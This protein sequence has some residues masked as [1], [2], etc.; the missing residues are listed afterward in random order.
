MSQ[1][2]SAITTLF[3]AAALT[4]FATELG[5]A[6]GGLANFGTMNFTPI[7]LG[8]NTMPHN[9]WL[10]PLGCPGGFGPVTAPMTATAPVN[11]RTSVDLGDGNRLEI[12][13][14]SSEIKIFDA[15]G[16][17]TRIW[18]D[19]HV[20]VNGKHV[21]DF[22][23]ATTFELKNGT[24]ITINTEPWQGNANMYVASQLVITHGNQGMVIDGVSQNK[25]GDLS[26]SHG[27]GQALDLMTPDGF[28]VHEQKAGAG[29]S[30]GWTS[31]FTGK[32]VTQADFDITRP[33]NEGQL[34]AAQFNHDMSNAVMSWL[35]FGNIGAF[36]SLANSET[37]HSEI[38]QTLTKALGLPPAFIQ[39]ALTHR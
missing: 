16:N 34:K 13:E 14:A 5:K 27:N 28:T 6:M 18:G 1:I 19:P 7:G 11:G 38:R 20:D 30:Y 24:K 23:Q 36:A 9:C 32:Q 12:N 17:E 2:G 31:E 26:I 39:A 35:F 25:L 29:H 4:T 3:N 10:P 22:Y 37:G 15:Q 8:G 33:G 21:G